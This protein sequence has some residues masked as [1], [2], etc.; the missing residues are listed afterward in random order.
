MTRPSANRRV[1][2]IHVLTAA[3]VAAV[4]LPGGALHAE[5][6][7]W[8]GGGGVDTSWQN[9]NNWDPSGVPISSTD[10]TFTNTGIPISG[11]NIPWS[12]TA[13]ANSVT[14]GTS[15]T[16][17]LQGTTLQLT[18]GDLTRQDV[19]QG[20]HT[21]N[22]DVVMQDD[23]LWDIAGAGALTVTKVSDSGFRSFT[24]TGAGFLYVNFLDNSGT[25]TVNQGTLKVDALGGSSSV[26][27]AAGAQLQVSGNI[28]VS[29]G[30]PLTL[31]GG[32]ISGTGALRVLGG[33]FNGISNLVTLGDNNVRIG[34][35]SGS[36]SLTGGVTDGTSSF[37]LTKVGAGTL[38]LGQSGIFN[39]YDGGT[40]I[41]QGIVS[42][43]A[44]S[45][46][47]TG[48]ATVS[49]GATLEIAEI[50]SVPYTVSNAVT[51]GGTVSSTTTVGGTVSGAVTLSANAIL[52]TPNANNTLTL[53]GGVTDNAGGFGLTKTGL[54][55]ALVAGGATFSG[56]ITVSAGVLTLASTVTPGAA[57]T[58]V[59]SGA[60]LQLGG[61]AA[62][63]RPL[64]V[65]GNGAGGVGA[66]TVV[67]GGTSS[68]PVTLQ[69]NTSMGSVSGTM[70]ISGPVTGAFALT[71]VGTGA[72]NLTNA[73]NSFTALNI[74]AGTVQVPSPAPLPAAAPIT[75]ASGGTLNLASDG[76]FDRDL[77]L[78]GGT[79]AGFSQEDV[80]WAAAIVTTGFSTLDAITGRLTISGNISG[81]GGSLHKSGFGE[82]V[83]S[84]SNSFSGQIIVDQGVLT[85]QGSGA[86]STSVTIRA[87]ATLQLKNTG[88]TN[89]GIV[90]DSQGASG[91]GGLFN[92]AGTNAVGFVQLNSAPS[93]GTA[94]GTTLT[95]SGEIIDGDPLSA[96]PQPLVKLGL[97]TLALTHENIYRGGT[98][99]NAG[100]L[101]I[102]S[103]D[104]L[105]R[106]TTFAPLSQVTVNNGAKLVVTASTST[107]RTFNLNTGNIQVNGGA[108]HA[109]AGSAT[110]FSGVT[111]LAGNNIIQ[112]GAMFL[113]NFSSAGAFVSNAP[114]TWDGGFNLGGGSV[115]VNSTLATE[116]F[117]ND[118]L[119]TIN[120][121][122]TVSNSGND[123]PSTGGSR[124]TINTGGTLQLNGTNLNL[125]GA[126][127]VNNG[128]INGTTNV[129]FG[130][131]AKGTGSY[132]TVNVFD[133]GTFSPG[134]S[135]GEVSVAAAGF[136][137]GGH[138]LF[139]IHDAV[140][141]PGIGLDF[142][143]LA[144]GLAI[145]AGNTPNSQFVIDL[146]SLDASNQPGPA[147]NF[148]PSQPYSFVLATAAGGITGFS[149]DVFRVD[150][151][152]FEN[153]LA[154]GSFTV[155]QSANDLVLNFLPAGTGQPGDFDFDGDV[156]GRD[157]LI[158]QQGGSPSPLSSTDLADWEAN[159]GAGPGAL[160]A[161]ATVPEP[162]TWIALL[163]VMVAAPFRRDC[164]TRFLDRR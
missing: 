92:A 119:I 163:W 146:V 11:I 93:I 56:P 35:D 144:G 107:A 14:I 108:T 62:I 6:R 55:T 53:S 46:L 88:T 60:T 135:P 122:G 82:V 66:L 151:S 91:Q 127:A 162:A 148:N 43:K 65:A 40:V 67:G 128:T 18:S 42:V 140:G 38:S 20:S 57:T 138:Y 133:G 61:G 130:S 147:V 120:S 132:G 10:V 68:G 118:G 24:K 15:R 154:G 153:D 41:E 134:A 32:G 37:G 80:T 17:T 69:A 19:F 64:E 113:N 96:P 129:Y 89:I 161:A 39:T 2:R 79:L 34:V 142:M 84:G 9:A 59:Q 75:V 3:L 4:G 86:L 149:A 27:I 99:V 50:I 73:G 54:G 51:L 157:F 106:D 150:A 70:T 110:N 115:T 97:G 31:F 71:K 52:D 77:T 123:L 26:S 30:R 78:N 13:N 102:D 111:A 48:A 5:P 49:P 158:W 28:N 137:A 126:L 103:D 12:G 164:T 112:N 25:G 76:T 155:G 105:G 21:I 156:D 36:L 98:I 94:A 85:G 139:E 143:D 160:A 63:D 72:L 121:G 74:S 58:T 152:D 8:D 47:G 81:P 29:I 109:I 136:N 114:L 90:L 101:S 116:A 7:S 16:M 45:A 22:A 87:G 95:I 33:S 141:L 1:L 104:R 100:T 131:L 125:H 159:Y 23:G 124:I 44:P 83:L 145:A 117:E